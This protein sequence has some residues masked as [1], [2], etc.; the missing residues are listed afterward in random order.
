MGTAAPLGMDPHVLLV[1]SILV[2]T[3]R[4]DS[5]RSHV[6]ALRKRRIKKPPMDFGDFE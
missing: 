2:N 1:K 6:R 5:V 3:A 4:S